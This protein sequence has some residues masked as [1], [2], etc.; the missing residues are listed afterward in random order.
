MESVKWSGS[1]AI[2]AIG[3]TVTV[4]TN[5][6]GAARVLEYRALD[7]FIGLWVQPLSPPAWYVQQND[8]TPCLV[9]GAELNED[10]Q[11]SVFNISTAIT[12]RRVR[13][14]IITGVEGGYSSFLVDTLHEADPD[15]GWPHKDFPGYAWWPLIRGSAC[16]FVDKYEWDDAEEKDDVPRLRLDRESIKK[17][18]MLMAD[19]YPR[20]FN[21]FVNDNDDAITGDVFLQCCLL[22]DVVYG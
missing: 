9:F 18:L 3:S 8:H 1:G 10:A 5:G 14:L 7:G 11:D 16:L 21:D 22:G 4:G 15:T 20:H 6:I 2:P 12:E 13:E 17:G 19:K